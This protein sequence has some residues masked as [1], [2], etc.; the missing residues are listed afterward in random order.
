VIVRRIVARAWLAAPGSEVDQARARAQEGD[1]DWARWVQELDR[2]EATLVDLR[3]T[4]EIE[5]RDGTEHAIAV[6]NHQIWVHLA[7]QPPIMAALVAE[8]SNKDFN[9]IA[10]RI[11]ALGDEVDAGELHEMYVTVELADDLLDALRPAPAR[12]GAGAG[13]GA[14]PGTVT[15]GAR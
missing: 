11:R 7:H 14:R 4:V 6:E 2:G 3:V 9:E 5:L 12:A 10:A 13:H 15:E 1:P 8:L